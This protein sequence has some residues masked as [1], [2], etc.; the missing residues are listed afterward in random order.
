MVPGNSMET[1]RGGIGR[2]RPSVSATQVLWLVFLHWPGTAIA[3]LWCAFNAAPFLAQGNSADL[4][5]ALISLSAAAAS[6]LGSAM[7]TSVALGRVKNVDFDRATT[8]S[9]VIASVWVGS[10]ALII[11]G[12]VIGI[13][14]NGGGSHGGMLAGQFVDDT[15]WTVIGVGSLLAVIGPGFSEYRQGRA[16]RTRPEPLETA[17]PDATPTPLPRELPT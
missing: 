1:D 12:A 9:R 15:L 8:T 2:G 7:A 14:T 3:L 4:R 11:G 13:L 16:K 6:L 5:L 17:D 10:L